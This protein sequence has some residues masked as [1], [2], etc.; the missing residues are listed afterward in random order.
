M[1]HL[2]VLILF[3]RAQQSAP[4]VQQRHKAILCVGFLP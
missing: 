4:E 3:N 1:P 2:I